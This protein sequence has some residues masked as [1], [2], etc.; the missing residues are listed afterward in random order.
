VPDVLR[1][2]R[3]YQN[4]SFGLNQVEARTGIGKVVWI[5]AVSPAHADNRAEDIGLYFDEN[6][7]MDCDC[8]G[9]RWSAQDTWY[10]EDSYEDLPGKTSAFYSP[11]Y[12]HPIEG[13]F[14]EIPVNDED[15]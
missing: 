5:Q 14:R 2:Y 15:F 13:E 3:Y 10:G 8:C 9:T 11:A 1:W 7:D 12:A 6:F 4:N